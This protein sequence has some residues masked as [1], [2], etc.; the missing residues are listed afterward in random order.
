MYAHVPEHTAGETFNA[1][2]HTQKGPIVRCQT[3]G[4][5]RCPSFGKSTD[6]ACTQ[7]PGYKT[8]ANIGNAKD[9]WLP[10]FSATG[11]EIAFLRNDGIWLM[12]KSGTDERLA[13]ATTD[14]H[15]LDW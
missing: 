12:S 6:P 4:A 2:L 9:A 13:F 5:N 7:A 8:C 10:R 1:F 11:E 3:L 14:A 15:G